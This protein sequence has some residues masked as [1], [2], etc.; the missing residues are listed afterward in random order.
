MT[1]AAAHAAAHAPG[2]H[3]VDHPALRRDN[4][5]FAPGSGKLGLPILGVGAVAAVAGLVLGN[6]GLGGATGVQGLAAFH[7]GACAVLAVCLAAT[8]FTMVFHL[9][10]AGWTATLRRQFENVMSFLPMAYLLAIVAVAADGLVLHGKLFRWMAPENY[11][12]HLLHAKWTYF[13]APADHG[14]GDHYVFPVFFFVRAVAYGVIWTTLSRRLISLSREQ[15]TNPDPSLT[16]KARFT[17]AWGILVMA[18]TTA[19]A[20]FDWLMSLDFR[21]FS[22]MWGVYFFA[23]GA[24]GLFATMGLIFAIIRKKGKLEGA[25]TREHFHDLG[26]LMFSFTV[27]W[28]YIAFSQYFLIWY[29]NI[30]EET[31]YFVYRKSHDWNGLSTFLVVGHFAV[32]FLFFLSRHIKKNM[33]LVVLGASWAILAH[34]AD[35]F[36]IVR[37]MVYAGAHNSGELPGK[38]AFLVDGLCIAGVVL[39]FAGYMARRVASTPLVAVNDPWMH[40]AL[41]HKNYV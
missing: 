21:F 39:V 30:P 23:G 16:A 4:V 9:L 2:H 33:N 18:L 41:E 11:A 25:V 6:M 26:K 3:R 37:P 34:L 40:E 31:A 13:F 5:N 19:F 27:F 24:F 36:W 38:G 1:H 14:H 17:S 22:T 28:G 35:L 7:V 29:S 10:N 15:D 8:I 20:G 32:P 12:D